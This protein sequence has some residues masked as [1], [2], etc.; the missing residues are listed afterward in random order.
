MLAVKH[1]LACTERF[2]HVDL[3]AMKKK[4]MALAPDELVVIQRF[5][6]E[7]GHARA[8]SLTKARRREI[9]VK[10]ARTRWPVKETP[11]EAL[12]DGKRPS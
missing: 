10:A 6:S 3:P 5:A 2:F 9:A 7:G 12:I 4:T 8:K 1:N 11:T